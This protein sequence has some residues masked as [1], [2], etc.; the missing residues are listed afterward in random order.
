ME[1]YIT[2]GK[3][4][5]E[6]VQNIKDGPERIQAARQAI[7]QAGGKWVG[8]YLTMGQ[9]DFVVITQGPNAQ[10]AAALTLAIGMQGNIRTE[11]LR[12]FTEEEFKSLVEGL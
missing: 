4:T 10:T 11:T 3:Y 2:L 6:G 7:E 5:R 9:Y 12:A 8:W 1:T